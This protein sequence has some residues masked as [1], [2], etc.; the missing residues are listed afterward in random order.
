MG[1]IHV[2]WR[3]KMNDQNRWEYE[4]QRWQEQ[5]EIK[6]NIVAGVKWTLAWGFFFVLMYT[7][8]SA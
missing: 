2:E 4:V 3:S 5:E 1:Q 8:L 6:R 7:I